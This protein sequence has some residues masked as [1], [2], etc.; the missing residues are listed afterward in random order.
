[1]VEAHLPSFVMATSYL[2][3]KLSVQVWV[4]SLVPLL[5]EGLNYPRENFY[6]HGNME[7]CLSW[8]L[9][10]SQSYLSVR[11]GRHDALN[12]TTELSSI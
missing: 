10:T 6:R 2:F 7:S 8:N 1:M 3:E 11:C 4:C 5:L 12:D 9:L